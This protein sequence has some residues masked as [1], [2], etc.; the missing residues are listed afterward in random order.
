MELRWYGRILR[1]QW[2]L[3]WKTVAIVALL[4]AL[5]T[6]YATYGA[7]YKATETV[8]FYQNQPIIGGQTLQ[9]NPEDTALAAA[10]ASTGFAKLFT[11]QVSFFKGIQN[12]LKAS[13]YNLNIDWK[14]IQAGMGANIIGGRQLELEY[15]S[16][17]QLTAEHI[18]SAAIQQVQADFLPIYNATVVQPGRRLNITTFPIQ[19]RIFDPLVSLT[20]KLSSAITGWLIKSLVGLVVGVFLAFLWEYLDESIHDE[21]DVR[22]WMK[23]PTLGVIPAGKSRAA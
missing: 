5:Y 22:N 8:E 15:T 12:T 11:E 2:G 21:Q 4:S 18:V 19:S 7:R 1:R 9:I 6:A 14:V 23:A 3:I 10:G 17:N 20:P 13:P 16:S